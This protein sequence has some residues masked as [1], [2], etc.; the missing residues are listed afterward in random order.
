MKAGYI[1]IKIRE[2]PHLKAYVGGRRPPGS[3]PPE[4]GKGKEQAESSFLVRCKKRY[5]YPLI[6]ESQ[7]G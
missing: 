4:A 6:G 3:S 5:P 1:K 2:G 7:E